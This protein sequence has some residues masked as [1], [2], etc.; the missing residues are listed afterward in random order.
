MGFLVP[1]KRGTHLNDFQD[2]RAES[3]PLLHLVRMLFAGRLPWLS[4]L[5]VGTLWAVMVTVIMADC[6]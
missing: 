2:S 5:S 6:D 3:L 1:C 4:T